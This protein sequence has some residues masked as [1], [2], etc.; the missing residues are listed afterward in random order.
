MWSVWKELKILLLIAFHKG[1]H[2]VILLLLAGSILMPSIW[3]FFF[4]QPTDPKNFKKTSV[5][6]SDW[7]ALINKIV[8]FEYG[9]RSRFLGYKV[10]CSNFY[11][12][13][14]LTI[15]IMSL[16]EHCLSLYHQVL[17]IHL[18][19]GLQNL[20]CVWFYVPGFPHP[21]GSYSMCYHCLHILFTKCRG[22]PLVSSLSLLNSDCCRH[23]CAISLQFTVAKHLQ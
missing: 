9:V 14:S 1:K 18:I 19:L 23:F 16:T 6:K 22:L 10:C 12:F 11:Y 15:Y 8:K 17:H 13:K 7:S 3:L 21:H 20:L 4:F 5:E 2:I